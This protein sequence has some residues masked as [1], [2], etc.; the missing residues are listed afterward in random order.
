M[1][2][3][4]EMTSAELSCKGPRRSLH[5][6][7]RLRRIP[8]TVSLWWPSLILP[9][10]RFQV[11]PTEWSSSQQEEALTLGPRLPLWWLSPIAHLSLLE[12]SA[13]SSCQPCAVGQQFGPLRFSPF[14]IKS[15][16]VF[17]SFLIYHGFQ[18]HGMLHPRHFHL[19]QVWF[20]SAL[21]SLAA[22][23]LNSCTRSLAVHIDGCFFLSVW[24]HILK[25]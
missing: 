6:T 21:E 17:Q 1:D 13:S 8:F 18:T 4:V 11:A 5:S 25:T 22:C 10:A 15:T 14:R 2:Y 16:L 3:R 24:Q 9:E 20:Y 12:T 7:S 19:Q 23:V